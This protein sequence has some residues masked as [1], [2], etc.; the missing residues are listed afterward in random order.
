MKD[1]RIG[2]IGSGGRGVI[3]GQAHKIGLGSRV[4]ACCDISPATLEKN[5]D[6][7]GADI[8]TT[9]DYHELLKQ[10]LDAVFVTVPDFLHEEVAIAAL[11]SGKAVYLE[12]PMAITIEG[13]D[14]VMQ[15]AYESGSRLYVG[16]N[17]R[18][19][20]FI[21]K[22]KELIDAGTIGQVKAVWCRH[23][24]GH[25]GDYYFKDWHAEAQYSNG[26]LLQKGAHDIDIIHWLTGGYSKLVHGFGGLTV[27]GGPENR[28]EPSEKPR[29]RPHGP[30]GDLWPPRNLDGKNPII[31]V[32]DISMMEM[33]LNNGVFAS[34]QQCHYTPDYWRNYTV[35]GDEGRLENFGNGEDGTSVHVWN[36]QKHSWSPPDEVHMIN[37][38][39]MEGHGGS[40]GRII[41]EFL[42]FVRYG[43]KTKTSPLAARYSVAAGCAATDSLRNGGIPIEVPAV[44]PELTNYFE[45]GQKSDGAESLLGNLR[46]GH[47]SQESNSAAFALN[48]KS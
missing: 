22:M 35:I 48:G 14:R 8:F 23:F 34:Y 44:T 18:H 24:V 28:A 38:A 5:R 45:N 3:A 15:A 2:V 37:T 10:E 20:K 46:N 27:Y 40:D 26:L 30:V 1:L 47:N 36:S 11:Q 31:D 4:V 25:G 9:S 43:G 19:M 29:Q 41:G 6:A 32:E 16:H 33:V 7:Y 12:K 17:M 13:C 39:S 21:L 42:D